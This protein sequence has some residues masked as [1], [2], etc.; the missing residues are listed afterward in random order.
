MPLHIYGHCSI[1]T[2][3]IFGRF[4]LRVLFCLLLPVSVF[5]QDSKNIELLDRW[6]ADTLLVNSL[7]MRY[8]DCWGFVVN[9]NEYAVAGSTEGTHFFQISSSNKLVPI[10]FVNGNFAD[11]S[12]IHRDMKSY[13]NYLYSVCDEGLSSLQIID[14]SFLPDSVSLVAED[15]F[16]FTQ[17]HNIFIDP[18][19]AL[20]YACLISPSS[21]GTLLPQLPMQVYSLADP[22]NPSLIYTG[23]ADIPEVHDSYVRNNIAY[24]NCGFEGLRIYDFSNPSAPVFLQNMS[25]YQEQGYNHQGWLSPDGTKYVFGDETNGKKLKFCTV[26]NNLLTIDSYFGSNF[27]E[28]SVPHNIVLSNEFAYVAYY[29]E[30]LRIY[31]LRELPPKEVAHYETHPEDEGIFT[32]RGAWGIY[33]NLP[34]ERILVSDRKNG[35]FLFDF[36]E[37][38]FVPTNS[39]DLIIFPNPMEQGSKI[40]FRVQDSDVEEFEFKLVDMSGKVVYSGSVSEQN[41]AEIDLI[42]AFG[43]YV[44]CV[45]FEDYLGDK[46]ELYEKIMVY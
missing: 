5:G 41:Y 31:D 40:R 46:V 21:G 33:P 18:T 35:L 6:S 34:S 23:P 7:G 28:N 39:H 2:L 20:M 11:A 17:V 25:I 12:V 16:N 32:M 37:E 1:F 36:R 22:V 26:E 19:N 4:M 10:D 13:G 14:V 15:Q 45:S 24:L 38:L 29:N 3:T 9:G 42:L 44:L 30:G 8:N 27:L 43:V